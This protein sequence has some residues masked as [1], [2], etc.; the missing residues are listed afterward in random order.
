[1]SAVDGLV[2]SQED[3]G[4]TPATLTIP[5]RQADISWLHLSRKLDLHRRGRSITD[6]FRHFLTPNQRKSHEARSS[7]SK[8]IALSQELQTK[9]YPN[10]AGEA[11]H[12]LS[13]G[14]LRTETANQNV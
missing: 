5:G 12:C 14:A 1:M 11:E 13:P 3:A 10:Q 4:A 8:P 2:R 6:A 7:L 9:S